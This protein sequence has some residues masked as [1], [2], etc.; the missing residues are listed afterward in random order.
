MRL[1]WSEEVGGR[2]QAIQPTGQSQNLIHAVHRAKL[3]PYRKSFPAPNCC[4]LILSMIR[5]LN[6]CSPAPSMHGRF[7][8]SISV[9]PVTELSGS[10][11]SLL[12]GELYLLWMVR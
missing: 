9:C 1:H 12:K 6:C 5:T 4:Q 8:Q 2:Q 3:T 7:L 11:I 10:C